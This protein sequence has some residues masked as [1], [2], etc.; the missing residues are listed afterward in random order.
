MTPKG[1]FLNVSLLGRGLTM[2][3][4]SRFVESSDLSNDF[5]DGYH[6]LCG[7]APRISVGM[8]RG[9]YGDRWVA[10]GDAAATR[11]YKDGI[12]S[13]FFTT[14]VAIETAYN[15]GISKMAFQ[16]HYA[17]YCRQI[18]HD[19]LY[20]KILFRLWEITIHTPSLLR[21]WKKA[22]QHERNLPASERA[23]MRILWGMLTGDEAYKDLARLFFRRSALMGLLGKPLEALPK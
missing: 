11:L 14:K 16:K 17:P 3:A 12:G 8:A 23:H 9:Y 21:A 6:G 7:C 20:G 1:R 15:H 10:V 13:A 5:I 2:D 19:N 18:S 4:I 22:I